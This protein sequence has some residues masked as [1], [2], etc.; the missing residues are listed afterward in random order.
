MIK[1][2]SEWFD[3]KYQGLSLEGKSWILYPKEEVKN[4]VLHIEHN[5]V[6][7]EINNPD[8]V[9]ITNYFFFFNKVE[10]AYS[11]GVL[12]VGDGK[13]AVVEVKK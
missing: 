5:G 8:Y 13:I 12:V 3:V 10:I 1:Y 9:R 4:I 11:R 6:T 2:L 7:Y